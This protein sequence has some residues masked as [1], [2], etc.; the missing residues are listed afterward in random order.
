MVLT[1]T[2]LAKV[3]QRVRSFVASQLNSKAPAMH[4]HTYSDIT[5]LPNGI[6]VDSTIDGTSANAFRSDEIEMPTVEYVLERLPSLN[7]K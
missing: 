5:D 7:W 4:T 2:G 1:E 6:A 3:F